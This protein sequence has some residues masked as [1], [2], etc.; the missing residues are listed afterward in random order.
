MWMVRESVDLI[1]YTYITLT[2]SNKW[3]ALKNVGPIAM[4]N[5]L[6]IVGKDEDGSDTE[7]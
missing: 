3:L 4:Q 5:A 7:Y 1:A 2:E 6:E